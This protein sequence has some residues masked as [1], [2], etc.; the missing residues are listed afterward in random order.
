[1]DPRGLRIK[2]R[3]RT[4]TPLIDGLTWP[5]WSRS[6]SRF[7]TRFWLWLCAHSEGQTARALG[8]LLN[9]VTVTSTNKNLKDKTKKRNNKTTTAGNAGPTEKCRQVKSFVVSDAVKFHWNK[10]LLP[11]GDFIADKIKAS[12]SVNSNTKVSVWVFYQHF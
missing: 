9:N 7:W 6:W 3:V 2:L 12:V 4:V 8:S 1:M 10:K 11:V 5:V